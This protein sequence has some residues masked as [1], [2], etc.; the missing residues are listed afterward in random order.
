MPKLTILKKESLNHNVRRFE[1]DKPEGFTFTPGQA[2]HVSINKG[3]LRDE[4]RPFTFT[5]LPGDPH[6][7]FTIKIYPSHEGVTD[8]LDDLNA[9]DELIIDEAWG[10]IQY[11]GRG[12]FIAGGAG[13]TPMLA[14]LRDQ[15]SKRSEAVDQ[16]FFANSSEKDLFLQEELEAISGRNLVLAYSEEDVDGAEHGRI[17]GAFLDKHLECTDQFFYVCGPPKM[18]DSIE[19]LLKERGVPSEKIVTEES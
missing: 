12:T 18:V 9:G 2:T 5:S 14:I 16:V 3:G 4:E 17:D 19:A 15:Y 6:L 7:E 1:T 11:K 10:A 8:Q 13:I